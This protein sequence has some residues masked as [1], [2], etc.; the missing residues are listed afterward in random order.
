M[1]DR[2]DFEK[3]FFTQKNGMTPYSLATAA[4]LAGRRPPAGWK[5]V[6]EPRGLLSPLKVVGGRLRDF[7]AG[8]F[9]LG[10]PVHHTDMERQVILAALD[11]L[12][13]AIAAAPE[14]E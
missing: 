5:L 3:W 6:R 9:A 10:E 8:R 1:S 13:D 12:A 14:R 11:V 2:D 4:F 7:Y